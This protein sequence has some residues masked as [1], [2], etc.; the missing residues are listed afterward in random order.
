MLGSTAAITVRLMVR[1]QD[2]AEARQALKE[3]GF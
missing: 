2:A 3:L 1:A